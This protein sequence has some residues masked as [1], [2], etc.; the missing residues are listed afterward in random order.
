MSSNLSFFCFSSLTR[1]YF[2]VKDSVLKNSCTKSTSNFVFLDHF[3]RLL[4]ATFPM[5][6]NS[7]FLNCRLQFFRCVGAVYSLDEEGHVIHRYTHNY[8]CLINL[9]YYSLILI[10]FYNSIK[11]ICTVLYLNNVLRCRSLSA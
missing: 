6:Y 9:L 4:G 10:L 3:K 8:S 11:W 5:I 2:K 1:C 7:R